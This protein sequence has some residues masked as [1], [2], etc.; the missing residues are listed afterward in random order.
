MSEAAPAPAALPS[1]A[2]EG[3]LVAARTVE[4]EAEPVHGAFDSEHLREIHRRLFQDLPHYAPGEFRRGTAPHIKLRVLE[5][6]GHRYRIHYGT[7]DAI[8]AGLAKHLST[9]QNIGALQDLSQPD[10]ARGMAELYAQLDYLHPFAEGNSR[11]LRVFTRQLAA[12]M[13]FNLHWGTKDADA[14]T[15]DRLYIARDK[16]VTLIAFPGLDM[17]KAMKAETRAEEVAYLEILAK[18]KKGPTL[19]SFIE[20]TCAPCAEG[21]DGTRNCRRD[22]ERGA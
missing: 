3:L 19:E 21:P 10:F 17:E 16:A 6:S 13:G 2:V 1:A 12:E 15:R 18:Y 22:R 7:G 20:E 8:D 4:L 5:T 9:V 14:L 11:T